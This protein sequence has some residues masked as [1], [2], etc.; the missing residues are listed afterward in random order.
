[1]R[2]QGSNWGLAFA[3][4]TFVV[5]G[6]S[7]D[8]NGTDLGRDVMP[9]DIVADVATEVPTDPGN[10]VVLTDLGTEVVADIVVTDISGDASSTPKCIQCLQPGIAMRFSK[11][12]V[13]E[14]SEPQG[15]VEF[16]NG[17]WAPD[18]DDSRLN[19]VLRLEKIEDDVEVPGG[20]LITAT[21]GSAWHNLT[22]EDVV[23]VGGNKI[24]SEYYFLNGATS[25]FN[26]KMKPDCTFESIGDDASLLFHPGPMDHAL[27][28][29]GGSE[30]M[31]FGTD[32]IPLSALKA[33]GSFNDTCTTIS[34]AYLRGCIAQE[35]SCLICSFGLAPDYSLW[36]INPDPTAEGT[37][38]DASYCAKTCGK[39]FWTNFG[40]F[41]GGLEVP[42]QCDYNGSGANNGYLIAGDWEAKSVP[43][44]DSPTVK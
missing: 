35:A 9:A 15:L 16:L 23:E 13:Q 5:L 11:L 29:S 17:I 12:N 33:T 10:E 25:E 42:L 27:I 6:C 20:K 24:P 34:D 26:I 18:I 41:V 2:V 40:A 8:N 4:S 22:V 19:V 32:R 39:R 37:V 36:E 7:S 21:V 43:F 44:G 28:C 30:A 3:V 1:M 14:P 38:C 31:G